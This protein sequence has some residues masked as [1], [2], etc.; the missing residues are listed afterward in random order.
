MAGEAHLGLARISYQWNNLQAAEQHGQ[1]C[2]QLTRQMES[3]DTFA[4]YAV[5]LARLRLAQADLPGALVVL[6]AAEAFVG[7]HRFV[8]RLPDI[9]AAQVLLLLRQGDLAAAAQL[10]QTHDL[11]ISQAR[12]HLA[13]GDASAAL[14]VLEPV[15]QQTE[16][17]DWQAER[18]TVMVLEAVAHHMHGEADKAVHVLGAA[19]ALAKPGGFVR[20][21]VDEGVPMA[22]L[23]S[24]ALARGS[25]PAYIRR[26]LAAFPAAEPDY[27]PAA[28]VSGPESEWVE[29]LSA[30]EREVLQLIAEGLSN[31]EIAARLYLSLHTVKVHAR[32]IYAK[33]AVTNRTQAVARGRV[34]GIVSEP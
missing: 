27:A 19:L 10:A 29:P 30:R 8:F 17:R 25:E 16:A 21:F 6:D 14:A 12:I 1:Q 23:L 33:L 9:A 18:L 7:R 11:P 26:L 31:Q 28:P 24:K 34:L 15:R 22:R 20:L 5:F 13:Q 2:L 32:N 3:T 4:S